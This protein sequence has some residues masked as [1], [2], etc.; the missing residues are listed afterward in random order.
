MF[1]KKFNRYGKEWKQFIAWLFATL[2]MPFVAYPFVREVTPAL[3]LDM[4]AILIFG[5]SW[6]IISFFL[7]I[8]I[9][10]NVR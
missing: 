6:G 3:Q 9:K 8:F 4:P 2:T 10:K 5:F 7:Y 1:S